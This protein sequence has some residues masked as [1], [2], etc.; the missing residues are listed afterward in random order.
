M[1]VCVVLLLSYNVVIFAFGQDWGIKTAVCS[2]A[3]IL[4]TGSRWPACGKM[5]VCTCLHTT[6]ETTANKL[7]LVYCHLLSCVHFIVDNVTF[8]CF[9]HIRSNLYRVHVYF[10]LLTWCYDILC[11]STENTTAE[12]QLT[13]YLQLINNCSFTFKEKELTLPKLCDKFPGITKLLSCLLCSRLLQHRWRESSLV[14][15]LSCGRC[16]HGCQ[17]HY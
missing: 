8:L 4:L 15:D 11:F 2:H 1:L 3:L 9:C 12:Q 14:V 6:T 7:N 17:T 10:I 16:G 13:E 5:A